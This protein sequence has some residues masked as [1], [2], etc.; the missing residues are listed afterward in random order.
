[1][2]VEI[3][4][5]F[6]VAGEDWRSQAS[7]S[8]H[9]VDHLIAR[10]ETGKARIRMCDGAAT[11]T[12]KGQRIGLSRSEYH[13]DLSPADA[14]G[15]VEE[16]AS[17]PALEKRRHEVH[18]DGVVWQIDEHLG[19]LSGLVTAD[20]ELPDE[21]HQ[22]ALPRWAGPEITHDR[23]YGSRALAMLL[24]AGGAGLADLVAGA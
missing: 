14:A 18:L 11:F 7:A 2:A 3:E 15:M 20:V 9:I 4:R 6:L 16:F 17:S 19:V 1:M 23:R 22:L 5:K 10:F 12:L 8:R 24:H 13:L 21:R